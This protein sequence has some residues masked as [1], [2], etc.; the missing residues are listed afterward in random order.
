M[1]QF[2]IILTFVF[3]QLITI[4][5][6]CLCPPPCL[7][8]PHPQPCD[9]FEAAFKNAGVVIKAR[10]V[11]I[12]DIPVSCH[13]GKLCDDSEDGMIIYNMELLDVF[14]GY[15]P[16][17]FFRRE[18]TRN[19]V[20][21]GSRFGKEEVMLNLGS[22]SQPTLH[23]CQFHRIWKSLSE[24]EIKFLEKHSRKSRLNEVDRLWNGQ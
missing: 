14:K 12:T 10:I 22:R 8:P 16:T 1:K 20:Q 17:K 23:Q 6:G 5:I 13:A 18:T 7:Y 9:S 3:I 11:N 15:P 19:V 2:P 21:C 4:S 24:D